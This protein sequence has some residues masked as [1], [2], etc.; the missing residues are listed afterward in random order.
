MVRGDRTYRPDRSI[1]PEL[2]AGAVVVQRPSGRVLLLH[3]GDED[4]WALPKGHVDPGE[5]LE[6]AAIREVR[7][8]TGLR[9]V[10]LG[11]EVAEVNYR[12]YAAQRGLNVHK[13]SVYFLAHTS[14]EEVQTEPIFDRSEWV[15]LDT[16]IRQVPFETDREVLRRA[17][18]RL[19]RGD[20]P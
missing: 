4:R 17:R 20:Q 19:Q 15:D 7:E 16:A 12:F 11:P 2:A 3:Y 5:S 10:Q 1:V 8:E 6:A 18:A 14:E 13:T 9:E